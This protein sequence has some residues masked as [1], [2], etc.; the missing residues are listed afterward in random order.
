MK[1]FFYL[2]AV[3]VFVTSCTQPFK[4]AKDGS[5]YKIVKSN[6]GKKV[7]PGNYIELYTVAKY[8]DSVLGST[9]ED[10]MPQ[11]VLYDT[12]QF[13]PVFKEIFR[14]IS[15]GDSIVLKISADSLINTG[16]GAPFMKKGNFILQYFKIS[17]V[18]AT[19]EQADSVAKTHM[20]IAKAR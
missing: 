9:Y 18:F 15:A 20:V 11:Y 13:P 12:A 4:K 17:N 14:D 6:N 10:G 7:V 2:L 5:Q 8:K 16:R 1:H 3:A 19:K